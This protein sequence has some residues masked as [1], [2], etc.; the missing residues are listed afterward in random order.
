M[1]RPQ[2][3]IGNKRGGNTLL[4]WFIIALMVPAAILAVFA[5]PLIGLM[6]LIDWTDNIRLKNFIKGK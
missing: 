4:Q 6:M 5:L 1:A 2:F 3:Y